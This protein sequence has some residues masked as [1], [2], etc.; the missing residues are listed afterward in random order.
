MR[1][2]YQ[3]PSCPPPPAY[4]YL[5]HPPPNPQEPHPINAP[6]DPDRR[7]RADAPLHHRPRNHLRI[8][9]PTDIPPPLDFLIAVLEDAHA[10]GALPPADA[11]RIS[12]WVIENQIAP[13]SGETPQQARTRLTVQGQTSLQLLKAALRDAR[14]KGAFPNSTADILSTWV[15]E[16]LIAPRTGETPHQIRTRLSAQTTPTGSPVPGSTPTLVQLVRN[17]QGGVV[18]IL[19]LDS[20]GS[21][22]IIDSDGRVVTNHHVV[23]DRRNVTVRMYNGREYTAA[24]LGV[25]SNADLAVVDIYDND[26][27]QPVPLGDSAQTDHAEDVVALGFP[28]GFQLGQSLIVTRGV[29]STKLNDPDGRN[30]GGVN[31]FRGVELLQTDAAINPGN[32]GGPLFNRTGQVIGVITSR[33]EQTPDGRPVQGISFA[34]AINEL[35]SRLTTL[36]GSGTPPPTTPTPVPAPAPTPGAATPTPVPATPPV[37]GWNR[38]RNGDYGFHIDTPPGWTVNKDTEELDYAFFRA[39]DEKA[40]LGIQAYDL[41]VSYSLQALA[42]WNRD[43]LTNHARDESWNIFEITSF[44]QKQEGGKRF[45]EFTYRFQSSTEFCVERGVER[46]YLSSWYPNKPHGFRIATYV[47]EHSRNRYTTTAREIQKTFTEWT[48]HWNRTHAWG[49]NVP[50]GWTLD[51]TDNTTDYSNFWAPNKAGGFEIFAHKLGPSW[52]LEDFKNWR[53]DTLNKLAES[54]EVYEPNPPTGIGGVPGARD[55][56]QLTYRAQTSSEYCI[57]KSVNLIALSRFFP[58][59][60][61]GFLVITGVCEHSLHLYDDERMEMLEGFRN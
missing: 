36:K 23:E 40:G 17:V 7:H 4:I 8:P 44:A 29:I 21:G 41:P 37:A 22:F 24:V 5:P 45:Y 51:E 1:V 25:D 13:N 58:G 18:Q 42:E 54:W 19:T 43:W 28:L 2:K 49:L 16:N 3:P 46:I 59:H 14:D 52:T 12:N 33:I 47:C 50:P 60:P 31:R 57:S 11:D 10:K 35:K 38:Y 20:S 53:V 39:P 26:N 48:P 30:V 32:S 9:E 56:Y 6:K 27:F 61:Y 34:V 15:I 55:K